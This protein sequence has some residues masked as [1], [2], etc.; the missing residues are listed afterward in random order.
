S[1]GNSHDQETHPAKDRQRLQALIEE[2]TVDCYNEDEQHAG[3]L[4]MIEDNVVCPFQAKVVGETVTVT[5]FE[6]PKSGYGLYRVCECKG[7][8]HQ[9]DVTSLEWMKQRPRGFEW[10][11]AYFA[12]R[13]GLVDL[14]EAEEE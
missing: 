4:T 10:I 11:E 6:W 7:K 1:R 8:K 12:W 9:V 2:A 13:G 5:G 14:M 3:L